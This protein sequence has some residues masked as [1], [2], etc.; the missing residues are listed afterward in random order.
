MDLLQLPYLSWI[1]CLLAGWLDFLFGGM[2]LG[3][4]KL[5]ERQ[6][7]KGKQRKSEGL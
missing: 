2:V 6:E 5:G 4:D 7:N 3:G 1:D